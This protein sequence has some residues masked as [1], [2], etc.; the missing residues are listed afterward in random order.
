MGGVTKVIGVVFLAEALFV[1]T[2][3]IP[4]V[5]LSR[6]PVQLVLG[7]KRSGFEATYSFHL[8]PRLRMRVSLP[9]VCLAFAEGRFERYLFR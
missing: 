9:S 7:I 2:A 1:C 5:G 4:A 3:F 6:F 8:L